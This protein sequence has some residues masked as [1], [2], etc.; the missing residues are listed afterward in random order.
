[1]ERWTMRG[2]EVV[3]FFCGEREP[4]RMLVEPEPKA[5]PSRVAQRQKTRLCRGCDSAA[6]RNIL[7]RA[8]E[9]LDRNLRIIIGHALVW[10]DEEAALR[11]ALPVPRPI[12]AKGAVTVINEE[13]LLMHLAYSPRSIL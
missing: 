7:H 2:N 1:M 8:L 5:S 4:R 13:R 6:G 9:L 12:L 10:R 3:R 11:E